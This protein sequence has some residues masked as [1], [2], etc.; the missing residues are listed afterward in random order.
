[1]TASGY[2]L[3]LNVVWFKR[4]LRLYDHAPL[5][6]AANNGPILPL[7]IV[8]PDYWALPD[9]SRRHW[10]FIHDSVT[11]LQSAIHALG[12]AL[13]VRTG[14]ACAVLEKLKHAIG[15]FTLWS[16][17]ETGNAWTYERDK[18]ILTWCKQNQILWHELPSHGVVRRLSSR[19]GWNEQRNKRM[20]EQIISRPADITFVQAISSDP[21]PS[22][23]DAL[24]GD[25]IG[26]VQ[27]GGRTEGL[28]V[29]QSFLHERGKKYLITISKP[30]ISARH[31]S[32]LSAHIAYGTLSVREIE[33]ATKTRLKE[34][35]LIENDEA[36]FFRKNLTAFLS[37][38][39]W[40]CHFVQKL[41]QQPSI[42][43]H[44]MHQSFEGMREENFRQ[45]YFEAWATGQTGYPLIDAAMR[46]LIANG[47]ITF[48][49]RA[50]LVSFAS[51]HLWLDWRKTAP[52]LAQLFTDYE[53][54]IHYAQFQ[55]QSGVTGIN[56]VRMYNPIKQSLDHDPDGKFIRRYVPELAQVSTQ[57]IHEPW[58][59][60]NPP[61][62]YPK[63]IVDHSTA[64]ASARMQI[65]ARR[66][67]ETFRDD[68]RSINSKLGSRH[69]QQRTN[70]QKG[71]ATDQLTLD[72]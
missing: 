30:G 25:A 38:L 13:I 44:C 23:D 12:G 21:L 24:F 62:D 53:P 3:P 26:S 58:R 72:L 8:E 69:K 6:S 64:I 18:Q 59:M 49:M 50:L 7:Y 57:W 66:H 4:D 51:Y 56:A 40:R 45:D 39:A 71:K 2:R 37:R 17:E 5:A 41:E 11:D 55:M 68:A 36:K 52:Y 47:W 35:A 20:A 61:S 1:M 60:P 27:H 34:L 46:S 33:Q 28:R 22:K 48:R 63:P 43:T 14:S 15:P 29:L 10:H 67:T 19:D 70:R 16:H 32:R 31:C 54:G 65:S 9:T 42:E